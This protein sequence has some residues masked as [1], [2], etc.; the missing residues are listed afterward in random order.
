MKD[1]IVGFAV[2]YT[3]T[4]FLNGMLNNLANAGA[5]NCI[6]Q[7]TNGCIE[8]NN[9]RTNMNELMAT[10]RALTRSF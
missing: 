6:P 1:F 5:N 4:K 7:N 2:S 8:R 10:S 9:N 3:V